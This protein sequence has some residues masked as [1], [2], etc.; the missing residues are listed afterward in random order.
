LNQKT[1]FDELK[2]DFEALKMGFEALKMSFW[3]LETGFEAGHGQWG[4]RR[5]RLARPTAPCSHFHF[6]YFS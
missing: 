1:N 2:M 4:L 3:A 6:L 5:S